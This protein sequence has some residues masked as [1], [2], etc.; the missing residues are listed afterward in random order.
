MYVRF[1][2]FAI[3]TFFVARIMKQLVPITGLVVTVNCFISSVGSIRQD[4]ASQQFR[5]LGTLAAT[6]RDYGQHKWTKLS[7]LKKNICL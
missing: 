7:S 2:R 3:H 1:L 4:I 6:F 5:L